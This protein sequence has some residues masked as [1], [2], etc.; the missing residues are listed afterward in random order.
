MPD[1][2]SPSQFDMYQVVAPLDLAAKDMALC[3]GRGDRDGKPVV[4]MAALGDA[5]DDTGYCFRFWAEANKS[6]SLTSRWVAPIANIAGPEARSPWIAY[7]CFPALPLPT[8][9][10]AHGGALPEAVVRSLGVALTE[11]LLT[12]HSNGLVYAGISPESVL[13]T[14]Q[15]PQL[16]GYGLVRAASPLGEERTAVPGVADQSLPPEQ[17]QGGQ[18]RPLGDIYALGSVLAYMATGSRAPEP[19]ALPLALRGVIV[20]CLNP[21]PAHRPQADELLKRLRGRSV[22]PSGELPES[23]ASALVAQ[24][25]KHAMQADMATSPPSPATI[26][27]AVTGGETLRVASMASPSRRMLIRGSASAAAGVAVGASGIVAWRNV[28]K[29]KPEPLPVLAVPG[30]APEPLWRYRLPGEVMKF[31][32]TGPL[33]AV[34]K[35]ESG[36]LG[37]NLREGKQIWVRDDLFPVGSPIYM[38]NGEVLIPESGSFSLLSASS[39]RVQWREQG[40]GVGK[41]FAMSSVLAGKNG[42]VWLLADETV[43]GGSGKR[44][45]VIRYRIRDRREMW[46]TVIPNEM[47]GDVQQAREGNLPPILYRNS[48]LLPNNHADARGE[49]LAYYAVGLRDGEKKWEQRYVKVRRSPSGVPKAMPGN[50]LVVS[51]SEDLHDGISGIGIKSGN[52]RWQIR[53]RSLVISNPDARENMLYFADAD[54]ATY[55]LDTRKGKIRWKT[56]STASTAP[57]GATIMLSDSGKTVLQ[58][59]ESEIGAFNARNGV[60][61]WRF[62]VVDD[63]SSIQSASVVGTSSGMA[64][65]ASGSD[66]YALPVD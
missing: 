45:L 23:L 39:G 51:V 59:T 60:P 36:L 58:S 9:L 47:T 44:K 48:L 57:L 13:L 64:V 25:T 28:G 56:D 3:I 24:S 11:A 50:L 7:D 52:E 33:R 38:G 63:G 41:R 42:S 16:T 17:R 27:A 2:V 10:S 55:A 53:T 65:V 5:A 1:G 49:H 40:Y 22:R 12:T 43:T 46:R 54:L 35:D 26:A 14:A 6:R 29:R 62:A 8:A 15:G 4:L 21:D 19:T 30:T 34:V 18:P 31:V 32:L 20:D 61:R 37:I 66:L